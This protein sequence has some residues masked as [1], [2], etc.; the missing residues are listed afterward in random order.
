L[1]YAGEALLH[2][3]T[4]VDWQTENWW[5]PGTRPEPID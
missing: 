4:K 1:S 2:N 5:L 3:R